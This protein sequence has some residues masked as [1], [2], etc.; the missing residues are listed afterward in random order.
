MNNASLLDLDPPTNNVLL[1]LSAQGQSHAITSNP[2]HTQQNENTNQA[3]NHL[4]NVKVDNWW[5][6]EIFVDEILTEVGVFPDKSSSNNEVD[7]IQDF[8]DRC[9]DIQIELPREQMTIHEP[10]ITPINSSEGF[11]LDDIVRA[12]SEEIAS[13]KNSIFHLTHHISLLERQYQGQVATLQ[14][15]LL[16]CHKSKERGSK[17]CNVTFK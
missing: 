4:D 16:N 17:W 12:Q 15:E 6:N 3:S 7:L 14:Q 1:K 2:S 10:V 13:L 5:E 8:D 11:P 9:T